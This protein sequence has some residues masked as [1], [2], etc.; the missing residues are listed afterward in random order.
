MQTTRRNEVSDADLTIDDEKK[1]KPLSFFVS[2]SN[3]PTMAAMSTSSQHWQGSNH[4]R[5]KLGG[6][7]VDNHTFYENGR[8]N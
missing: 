4:S 7:I 3:V 6:G 2:Q 5:G 1:K 8:Q